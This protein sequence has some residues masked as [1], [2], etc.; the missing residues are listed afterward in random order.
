MKTET[1]KRHVEFSVAT[2]ILHWLRALCI[3]FLIATGFYLG[4]P[5]IIPVQNAE[6]TGFLYALIR[7]WHQI[8]GFALIGVTLFRV[9]IFFF[10]KGAKQER[11]TFD[12]VLKPSVWIAIIKAY[13]LIGHHPHQK[14][15]YNPIQ[16]VTYIMIMLLIFVMCIT[17]LTLYANVYHEGLGGFIGG[18]F[19]PV[20]VMLGGLS[21]VRLIHHYATWVF[22]IFVP[23]HIYLATWNAVRYPG[24]GLDT[25]AG[26]YRYDKD[27]H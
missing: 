25:M 15:A 4:Y 19:K 11:L 8:I 12:D 9:Y 6:P 13:L 1:F 27:S 24:G 7:S 18:I 20:E 2:R 16:L 22:V 5:F 3:F 23:L 14:G 21:S 10:S 17:G 26:G